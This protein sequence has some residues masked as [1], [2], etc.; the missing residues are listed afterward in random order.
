MQNELKKIISNMITTSWGERS[1]HDS[2]CIVLI[3]SLTNDVTKGRRIKHSY[4]NAQNKAFQILHTLLEFQKISIEHIEK[5]KK[6]NLIIINSKNQII[7]SRQNCL[8]I[9]TYLYFVK[10]WKRISIKITCR[11]RTSQ[12]MAEKLPLEKWKGFGE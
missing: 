6:N 2:T 7:H 5:T 3:V 4:H 11:G 1:R 9:T 12:R 8:Y 10:Q